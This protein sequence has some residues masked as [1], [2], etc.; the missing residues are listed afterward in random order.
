MQQVLRLLVQLFG[1]L[2]APDHFSMVQCFVHLNDPLLATELLSGLLSAE[3]RKADPDSVLK[4]YQIGFDLAETASQEFLG[5]ISSGLQSSEGASSSLPPANEDAE[6]METDTLLPS[7]SAAPAQSSSSAADTSDPRQKL[8]SILSGRE[9]IVLHLEFMYTNSRTDLQIINKS[10]D[11]L[12]ARNSIFHNA[13]T[14]N[15]AFLNAGTCS[16]KFLR[17]NL[18]WL[19][20][21]SNWSKF[22]ATAALGVIHRGNLDYGMQLLQPYLPNLGGGASGGPGASVYSEGGALYGLGLV[23]ANNGAAGGKAKE[24]T[25]FIRTALKAEGGEVVQHGAALGLGV[26]AM[27][28]GNEGACVQFPPCRRCLMEC[29]VP[30]RDLR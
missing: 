22:S 21:A 19:A 24:A 30:R 26:A 2:P 14:F 3:S 8:Q 5:V 12:E 23:H 11:L 10:K 27:A 4:A 7:T 6:S 13:I 1:S 29:F 28:T 9:T 17:D 18:E 25:E 16:D 20:K 15:N